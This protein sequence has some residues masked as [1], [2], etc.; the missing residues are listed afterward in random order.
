MPALREFGKELNLTSP[1]EVK[2]G[3]RLLA[4]HGKPESVGSIEPW[5]AW[6]AANP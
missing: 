4:S 5:N 1:F 3:S 6:Q 2:P